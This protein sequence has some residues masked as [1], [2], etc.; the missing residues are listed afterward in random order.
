[1]QTGAAYQGWTGARAGASTGL[2]RGDYGFAADSCVLLPLRPVLRFQTLL[3]RAA[4]WLIVLP[5]P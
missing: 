5:A 1:M 4:A 3:S 2:S